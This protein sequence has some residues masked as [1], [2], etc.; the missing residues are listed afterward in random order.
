MRITICGSLQFASK[1]LEIEQQ[2]IA[3]GHEPIVP[4]ETEKFLAWWLP[5]DRS[6]WSSEFARAGMLGHYENISNS[7][8]IVVA[9]FEKN[10]I[11]WYIGGAVLIEMWVACHLKKK[12]FVLHNLPSHNEVRYVQEINL[13]SPVIIN[14]DLSL[15]K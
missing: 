7:D 3:L 4:L 12:I 10:G 6:T 9:N 13:M 2:L 5:N 15:I 14:N 11:K 8:A 1:I